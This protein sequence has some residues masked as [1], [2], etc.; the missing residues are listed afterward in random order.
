MY[1][2]LQGFEVISYQLL[3]IGFCSSMV[4]TSR[5]HNRLYSDLH[6]FEGIPEWHLG[7]DV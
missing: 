5:V 1:E 7:M 3:V 6:A 2:F 4:F